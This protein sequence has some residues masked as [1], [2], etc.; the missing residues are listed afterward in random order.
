LYGELLRWFGIWLL[1]ATNVG[2]QQHYY[3]RVGE[4]TIYS[5][6][7]FRLN[8]IMSRNRFNNILG[9][10]EFHAQTAP[11][12]KDKLWMVREVIRA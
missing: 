2:A 12:Y 4:P 3:W 1:M 8:N 5:H 6:V 7:Q 9:W 11:L 10:L